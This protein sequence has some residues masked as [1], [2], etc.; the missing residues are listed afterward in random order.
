MLLFRISVE[1]NVEPL[2]A[3]TVCNSQ[4]AIE[5]LPVYFYLII[6]RIQLDCF[7]MSVLLSVCTMQQNVAKVSKNILSF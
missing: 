1:L 2:I 4:L 6:G 5:Q 7:D 3:H